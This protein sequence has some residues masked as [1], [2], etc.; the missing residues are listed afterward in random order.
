LADR[1]TG[2]RRT[3][4][5]FFSISKPVFADRNTDF[6]R[7]GNRFFPILKP[8]LQT[9]KPVFANLKTGFG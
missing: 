9:Q 7:P 4:N 1:K 6:Y 5:R 2:F 8:D 3:E